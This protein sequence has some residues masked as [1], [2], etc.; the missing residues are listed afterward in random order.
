MRLNHTYLVFKQILAFFFHSNV[1]HC[2]Y[3]IEW[4]LQWSVMAQQCCFVIWDSLLIL[5]QKNEHEL[6]RKYRLILHQAL[7]YKISKV[8]LFSLGL[9]IF[10]CLLIH[11]H[12]RFLFGWVFFCQD[13]HLKCFTTHRWQE[14][15]TVYPRTNKQNQ[16]KKRKVDPPTQQVMIGATLPDKECFLT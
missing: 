8:S 14:A 4:C 6:W 7:R 11:H 9:C 1:Y 16:K 15:L 10:V 3:K 2:F 5:R 13:Y 12:S